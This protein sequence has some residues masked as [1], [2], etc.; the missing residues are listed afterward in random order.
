MPGVQHDQAE[1]LDPRLARAGARSF[2][3][4][5][6]V[7]DQPEGIVQGGGLDVG[8]R[9]FQHDAQ[10]GV[11]ARRLEAN[12]LHQAVIDHLDPGAGDARGEAG[13]RVLPHAPRP[14]RTRAVPPVSTTILVKDG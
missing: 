12:L 3:R 5:V 14:A 6:D 9:P 1:R 11:G 13:A 2:P 7:Q 4:A 8:G 10:E